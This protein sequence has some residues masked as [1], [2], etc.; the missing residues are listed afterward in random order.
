M[1]D[2]TSLRAPFRDVREKRQ[3]TLNSDILRKGSRLECALEGARGGPRTAK[4][5]RYWSATQYRGRRDGMQR[6]GCREPV[7]EREEKGPRIARVSR[8][9]KARQGLRTLR[10]ESTGSACGS[11]PFSWVPLRFMSLFFGAGCLAR[12]P[13]V[14]GEGKEN[15]KECKTGSVI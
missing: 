9:V 5:K 2:G 13:V 6:D 7:R 12:L 4:P 11:V 1:L 10:G 3:E 14:R 15:G 8:W